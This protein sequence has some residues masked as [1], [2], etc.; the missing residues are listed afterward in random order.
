VPLFATFCHFKGKGFGGQAGFLK[1]NKDLAKLLQV[2]Y[3]PRNLFKDQCPK[4]MFE[5]SF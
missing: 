3:S 5:G 4:A 2:Q 1:N